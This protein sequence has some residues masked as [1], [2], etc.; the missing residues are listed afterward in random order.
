MLDHPTNDATIDPG[1]V[2]SKRDI[3]LF[4]FRGPNGLETVRL[5]EFVTN[6]N[7]QPIKTYGDAYEVI[8]AAIK[9][10]VVA[11]WDISNARAIGL[12]RTDKFTEDRLNFLR[13]QALAQFER[14][15]LG[16]LV[17]IGDAEVAAEFQSEAKGKAA[18]LRCA[19]LTADFRTRREALNFASTLRGQPLDQPV[20]HATETDARSADHWGGRPA[21]MLLGMR[22]DSVLGVFH[23]DS[24]FRLVARGRTLES[25]APQLRDAAPRIRA[26]LEKLA[27]ERLEIGRARDDSGQFEIADHIDYQSYGVTPALSPWHR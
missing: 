17:H 26:D 18:P 13:F 16:P 2:A 25:S 8:N 5:G 6:Y 7:R 15:N 22:E 19:V 12:D 1:P 21:R 3:P 27:L 10:S 14:D 23:T 11:D 20:W 4:S 24:G 9:G